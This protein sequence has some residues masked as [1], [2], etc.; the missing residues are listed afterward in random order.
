[1]SYTRTI[2]RQGIVVLPFAL[3]MDC[4]DRK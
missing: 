3:S 1:L 4:T 2:A